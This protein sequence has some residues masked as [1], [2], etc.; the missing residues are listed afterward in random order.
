VA[1]PAGPPSHAQ[2]RTAALRADVS[3]LGRLLGQVLVEQRGEALLDAEESAR[4]LAKAL[5]ADGTPEDER[6]R[7]D[8]DLA[9]LAESFDVDTL[10]D[11][12]SVV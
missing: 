11:R 9:D 6:D 2:D 1:V 3:Y 8:G 4:A 10:V 7:L 5:R 12:K